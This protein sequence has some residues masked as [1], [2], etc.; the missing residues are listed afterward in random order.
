MLSQW[1]LKATRKTPLT[2]QPR[3]KVTTALLGKMISQSPKS[4]RFPKS[5]LRLIGNA[6]TTSAQRPTS[7][8]WE[9][10]QSLR[11]HISIRCSRKL[12]KSQCKDW[13][14]MRKTGFLISLWETTSNKLI[15]K[16]RI[17]RSGEINRF[18]KNTLTTLDSEMTLCTPKYI[19]NTK[20]ISLTS[21]SESPTLKEEEVVLTLRVTCQ[22]ASTPDTK[23]RWGSQ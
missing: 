6:L 22:E 19:L 5:L 8:F 16:I 10:T 2:W 20:R 18:K 15:S 14:I 21:R 4:V 23:T 13:A 1:V 7:K 3:L 11:L 9:L 12:L 17:E